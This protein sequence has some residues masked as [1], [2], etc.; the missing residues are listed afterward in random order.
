M[1][2]GKAVAAVAGAAVFQAFT[3][4]SFLTASRAAWGWQLTVPGNA[5][6]SCAE[7]S[8]IGCASFNGCE[9]SNFTCTVVPAEGKSCDVSSISVQCTDLAD[10]T[11]MPFQPNL[12]Q[13]INVQAYADSNNKTM[14]EVAWSQVPMCMNA[15]TTTG[16][17][18]STSS[19]AGLQVLG[20]VTAVVAALS[21]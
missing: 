4:L 21:A 16:G 19:A 1:A 20:S 13:C 11:S 8:T 14:D 12:G 18:S 6:F 7:G 17:S 9:A 2:F 5:D 15:T 10:N 3:G